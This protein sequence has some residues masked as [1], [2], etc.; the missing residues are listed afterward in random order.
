MGSTVIDVFA[1][2]E[3]ESHLAREALERNLYAV[4]PT[5]PKAVAEAG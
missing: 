4:L 1:I 3:P 2:S 5:P